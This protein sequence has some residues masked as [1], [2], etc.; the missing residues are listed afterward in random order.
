MGTTIFNN[1]KATD[2]DAGVNGAVEYFV[3]EGAA[4]AINLTSDNND[5][6]NGTSIADGYGIFAISY[7]HQGDVSCYF[8]FL[9][10][11][12]THFFHTIFF[13][14]FFLLAHL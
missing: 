4:A 7:P 6:L 14:R 5:P 11:V 3:V 10:A 9:L 1:I 12:R 8:F 2:I 13:S